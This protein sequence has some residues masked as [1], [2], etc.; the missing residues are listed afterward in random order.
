MRRGMNV[1]RLNLPHGTVE[2]HRED[3]RRIRFVAAK[4]DRSCMILADLPGPKIRVG[5]L[6]S[7]P[8]IL[9]KGDTVTLTTI[10]V[11]GT[12][13]RISVNYERLPES[14]TPGNVIF[15]N[16]GFIQLHVQEVSGTEVTCKVVI[17]GPLLSNK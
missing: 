5:K 10:N 13:S 8:I 11:P 16:D 17:G 15:L 2:G 3:I 6:Q 1:A 7:E 12:T 4:L 14:V 9:K